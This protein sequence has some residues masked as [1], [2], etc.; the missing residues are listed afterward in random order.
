MSASV[1]VM[2]CVHDQPQPD[3]R[4]NEPESL[5]ARD[6]HA[7]HRVL[8]GLRGRAR[9]R[10]ESGLRL[11]GR[12]DRRPA[13]VLPP[14]GRR[15]GRTVPGHRQGRPDTG[16]GAVRPRQLG[17]PA[18]Q[19][20][21]PLRLR[22]DDR[23]ADG[24]HAVRPLLPGLRLSGPAGV[25]GRQFRLRAVPGGGVR[26]DL[27][28]ARR[29]PVLVPGRPGHKPAPVP[30]LPPG[31]AARVGG[32]AVLGGAAVAGRGACGPGAGGGVSG[33]PGGLRTRLLLRLGAVRACD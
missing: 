21:L 15:P 20:A 18:R 28:R 1:Y 32:A 29:V 26:G 16:H 30:L 5:G 24:P 3:R 12:A 23:G 17:A 10:A 25:R 33:P 8:S 27:R 2:L 4:P 22:R 19:H 6:I 13:H 11:R 9:G 7:A 31:T 14:L